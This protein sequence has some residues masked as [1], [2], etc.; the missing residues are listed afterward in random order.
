MRHTQVKLTLAKESPNII[1]VHDV[2]SHMSLQR[3]RQSC[4]TALGPETEAR[5]FAPRE[6]IHW[7]CQQDYQLHSLKL[8]VMQLLTKKLK[9]QNNE[10]R[11][12]RR[13]ARLL[14]SLTTAFEGLAAHAL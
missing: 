10:E 11:R 6:V 8:I 1:L 3:C 2:K 14:S 5:I 12:G 13:I 9:N 4:A 7:V